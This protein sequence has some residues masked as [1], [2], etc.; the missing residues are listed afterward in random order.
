[1]SGQPSDESSEQEDIKKLKDHIKDLGDLLDDLYKKV[2]ENFNLPKIE[3][4]I[5]SIN[6]YCHKSGSESI[7]CEHNVKSHHYYKDREIMCYSD[8]PYFPSKIKCTED[9]DRSVELFDSLQTISF[10]EKIKDNSLNIFYAA[11]P[12]VLKKSNDR[13]ILIN[14]DAYTDSKGQTKENPEISKRKIDESSYTIE[15]YDDIRYIKIYVTLGGSN[16][17]EI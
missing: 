7:L 11:F 9:N 17:L 10:L 16:I 12:E 2:Q 15:Y 4:S 13:D 14:L 3:S 5:T 6:S 1:M 8:M